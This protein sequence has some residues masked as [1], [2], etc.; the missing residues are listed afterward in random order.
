VNAKNGY[1][2][3]A[4]TVAIGKGHEDVANVLRNAGAME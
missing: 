4:L 2:K 1:G 3:T